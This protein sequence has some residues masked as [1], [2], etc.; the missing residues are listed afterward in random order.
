MKANP[1][2]IPVVSAFLLSACASS[3][4]DAS[5]GASARSAPLT[6]ATGRFQPAPASAPYAVEVESAVGEALPTFAHGGRTYVMG[7]LGERY[8]VH[9]RNPTGARVEAVVSIDGLDAIDG[10][11]ADFAHKRG[12]VIAPHEDLV[13][14]GFRT[15]LDQVAT[16]RF[17]PVA[18]SYA[19]RKGKARNVGVIG[20]AFFPERQ[21][22]R[23][24]AWHAPIE[25]SRRVDSPP[26]PSRDDEGGRAEKSAAAPAPGDSS[27][28]SAAESAAG[29]SAPGDGAARS[30]SASPPRSGL[31]TEFGEA[32]ASHVDYTRFQRA[33]AAQP[34]GVAELRYNDRRGLLA[35]GIDV[36]HTEDRDD[37]ALRES[38]QPFPGHAF[39]SPPPAR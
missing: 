16:F 11:P 32:R 33:N 34:S 12:Y 13:L 6:D 30:R 20:V 17:S 26:A 35:L 4:A 29:A 39:A 27:P 5:G 18:D 36:D 3:Y 10:E 7:S 1:L 19:G 14:E 23:R 9:I 31:G 21:A 22:V 8:R 38:A 15:S 37:V 2:L 28:P 24:P 25:E